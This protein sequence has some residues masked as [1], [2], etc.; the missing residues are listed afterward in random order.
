M[1]VIIKNKT[2]SIFENDISN[3]CFIVTYN[4]YKFMGVDGI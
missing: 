2:L 3:H 1:L 4:K